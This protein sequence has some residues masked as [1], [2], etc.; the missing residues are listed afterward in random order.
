MDCFSSSSS[1]RD[2]I[3]VWVRVRAAALPSVAICFDSLIASVGEVCWR[4]F[5]RDVGGEES[6]GRNGRLEKANRHGR[7]EA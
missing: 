1:S 5:R 4:C 2:R 7:G 3:R 6:G